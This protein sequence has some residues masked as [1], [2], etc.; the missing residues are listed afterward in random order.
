MF[1]HLCQRFPDKLRSHFQ[2]WKE[3]RRLLETAMANGALRPINSDF[4]SCLEVE[5]L[6]FRQRFGESIS[7]TLTT[8]LREASNAKEFFKAIYS[9]NWMKTCLDKGEF[10]HLKFLLRAYCQRGMTSVPCETVISYLH[11]IMTDPERDH[12]EYTQLESLLA[13]KNLY[14]DVELKSHSFKAEFETAVN[15]YGKNNVPKNPNTC[16]TC[17]FL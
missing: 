6:R 4:F 2:K 8:L 5:I 15:I 1:E 7:I 11:K 13:V 10:L 16:Y 9:K 14:K 12:M 3:N 17:Q